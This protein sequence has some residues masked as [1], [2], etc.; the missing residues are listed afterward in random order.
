MDEK[1]LLSSLPAKLKFQLH[2]P[3]KNSHEHCE[4]NGEEDGGDEQD[5]DVRRQ[6]PVGGG[7][8]EEYRPNHLVYGIQCTV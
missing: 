5:G 6:L 7:Q 1:F 4:R 2:Y 8:R 3:R